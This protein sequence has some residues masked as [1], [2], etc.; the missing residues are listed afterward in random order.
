MKI[1]ITTT[2]DRQVEFELIPGSSIYIDYHGNGGN[3]GN[4]GGNGRGG[5]GGEESLYCRWEDLSGDLQKKLKTLNDSLNKQI[6]EAFS[7]LSP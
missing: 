7:M 6:K 2:N 4:G 5:D 3:G 1:D